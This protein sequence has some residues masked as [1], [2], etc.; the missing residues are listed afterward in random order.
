[1]LT[2]VLIFFFHQVE[3]HPVEFKNNLVNFLG[4]YLLALKTILEKFN[5]QKADKFNWNIYVVVCFTT[6]L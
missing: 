3:E 1:M 5:F 6:F 4:Q 2:N